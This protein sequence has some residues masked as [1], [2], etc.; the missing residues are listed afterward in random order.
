MIGILGFLCTRGLWMD[1]EQEESPVPT[2]QQKFLMMRHELLKHYEGIDEEAYGVVAAM[3]L[4]DKSALDKEVREVYSKTGASHVLALSGLHLMMIYGVVSF[5]VTW[6]RWRLFAQ[7]LV[8]VCIWMFAFLVGLPSSVVRSATMI[9]I[10][11]VFATAHRTRKPFRT[12]IFT[13]VVMLLLRPESIRDIGFQLSFLAVTAI[14]LFH[15]LLQQMIP[16][17]V[18]WRHRWLRYLWG[19]TTISV[20]AQLGT[21]PLV[22]YY[23]GRLPV[24]FLLSN[25]VVIPLVTLILYEAL[26]LFTL[27]WINILHPYIVDGISATVGLLNRLLSAIAQWPGSSIDH[28]HIGVAQLL[29]VYLIIGCTYVLITYSLTSV[30]YRSGWRPPLGG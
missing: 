4:G 2:I 27:G 22:A 3:T 18:L 14:L 10:Y 16:S 8:V 7:A 25:Y 6:R 28:I 15:P 30:G 29:L 24:Y 12:L 9:T 21:A 5:L 20:S 23:F 11:T 1:M 26:L 17:A 19:L 13:A